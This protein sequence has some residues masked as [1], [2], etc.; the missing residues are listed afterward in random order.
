MKEI[1][2][3]DSEKAKQIN[4]KLKFLKNLKDPGNIFL[5]F[6]STSSGGLLKKKT[7]N[8]KIFYKYESKFKI[9]QKIIFSNTY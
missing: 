9:F 3:K 7:Y 4:K 5:G 6:S 8:F 2:E 1:K